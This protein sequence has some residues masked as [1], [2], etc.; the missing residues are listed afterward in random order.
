MKSLLF[1]VFKIFYSYA[2]FSIVDTK[3]QL[4]FFS[5]TNTQFM[6]QFTIFSQLLTQSQHFTPVCANFK[7]QVKVKHFSQK[8][9]IVGQYLIFG[10]R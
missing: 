3:T 6:K 10:F 9:I 1:T 4:Q 7:L 5:I 2:L 8:H